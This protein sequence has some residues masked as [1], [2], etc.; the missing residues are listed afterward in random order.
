MKFPRRFFRR[1]L[2]NTLLEH[3]LDVEVRCMYQFGSKEGSWPKHFWLRSLKEFEK[4]WPQIA[5]LN[6]R[7]YDV[8]FTVVPRLRRFQ[9]KK[10]HPLPDKPIF[11]CFWADLDVGEGKP[12]KSAAEALDKIRAT[13]PTPNIIVE[14]GTGLHA[15]YQLDEPQS[16][17]RERAEALLRSLAKQLDADP[18]AARATRIMRVPNTINWKDWRNKPTY[19]AWYLRKSGYSLETL[20]SLWKVPKAEDDKEKQ[21]I[22]GDRDRDYFDLFSPHVERLTRSGEWARGLCPFHDDHNPSFSLNVHTGRWVCFACGKEGNWSQFR[23]EI[24]VVVLDDNTNGRKTAHRFDWKSLPRFNPTKAP[25]TKWLVEDLVPERGITMIVGASGAFKSTFMLFM[26]DAVSKGEEFLDRKTRR[27]R[28][29]YLDNENPPDVLKA[30]NENMKLE[31]EAN[32]KLRLWSM[33]DE[34]PVPKILGG[35]LRKIV[36]ISVSDGRK[37]LIILDHWSSFLRPGEGGETTGQISPLMQEL[38]H[39]CALGATVVILHHTRKYEVDIEYGGADLR[40]KSDAIHTFVLHEDRLDPNRRIIRVEC[41]L[42]RHGGSYSFALRPRVA[43]GQ[44]VGFETVEDPI[45][46]E[47]KEKREKMRELIRKNPRLS[48]HD[49]VK[50]AQEQGLSRDEARKIL[51]RGAGKYWE[52]KTGAHGRQ[53]YQLLED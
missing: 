53:N 3:H 46:V 14:S 50:K 48:K 32:R 44:V 19:K 4:E 23:K 31:M 34:R 33:Y 13:K 36:R 8:H 39:L 30:R 17:T 28:V 7:V 37:P 45:K 9:G 2:R 52:I 24:G 35:E 18:G 20:E 22:E 11:A 15:Y 5:E 47:R 40:A 42:K 51:R 26:A 21:G 12:Y 10:E 16:I 43:M 41:F 1:I 38:K 29:L 27:R 6:E 49:L 25:K